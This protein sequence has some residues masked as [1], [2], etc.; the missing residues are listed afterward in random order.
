MNT[1]QQ[2]QSPEIQGKIYAACFNLTKN[3]EK[4]AELRQDVMYYA[5][6]GISSYN[7][8]GKLIHWLRMIVRNTFINQYRK[9][10]RKKIVDLL[11]W[12]EGSESNRAEYFQ[13]VETIWKAID[14]LPKKSKDAL[15]LLIEGYHYDEIAEMQDVAIGTVKS[16]IFHARKQ[17]AEKLG[18][19]FKT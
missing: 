14:S 2:I 9:A 6:R 4:A 15:M 5:M 3:H 19:E 11:E 18:I 8:E 1:I 12:K 7:E 16:R 17:L 13:E 10:N